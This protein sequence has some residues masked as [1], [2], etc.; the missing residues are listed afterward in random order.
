MGVWLMGRWLMSL[1]LKQTTEPRRVD[2]R[3]LGACG[4]Q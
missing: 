3:K 2:G 1:W 4:A